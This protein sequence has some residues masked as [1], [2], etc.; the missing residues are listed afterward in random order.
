MTSSL[1]RT[2]AAVLLA[3]LVTGCSLDGG[4]LRTRPAP[5]PVPSSDPVAA[6]LPQGRG[7]IPAG[8]LPD[9]GKVDGNDPAAVAEAALTTMWTVDTDIDTSLMDGERRAAPM[10]TARRAEGAAATTPRAQPGDLWNTWASHHAFTTVQARQ[11][12]EDGGPSDGP[13]TAYQRWAVTVTPRGRD[14]WT[15][16]SEV[17]VAL[18]VLLRDDTARPWRLDTLNLG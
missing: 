7:G 11:S 12:H 6:P 17:H 16:P 2:A 13:T 5:P 15:G 8:G 3:V 9:F 18:V 1:K 4:P 14:S 10:F